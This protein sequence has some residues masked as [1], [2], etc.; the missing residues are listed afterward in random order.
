MSTTEKIFYTI[1]EVATLL[2]EPESTLRY[3]EDEFPDIITPNR[4]E[5]GVRYYKESDIQDVRLIQHFIRGSGLTLEGVR[6]K[7]KHNKD[8][9]IKQ[10]NVVIR[11][12]N[13][14]EELKSLSNAFDKTAKR[15]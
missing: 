13:I 4:N 9:A 14:K 11:L 5:R 2:K 12:K 3:W 6:K 15:P 7:L 10:A 8:V 1:K